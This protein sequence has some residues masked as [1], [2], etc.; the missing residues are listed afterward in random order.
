MDYLFQS[1]FSLSWLLT[2]I[3]IMSEK[4]TLFNLLTQNDQVK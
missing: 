3:N 1:C 2:Y 4:G